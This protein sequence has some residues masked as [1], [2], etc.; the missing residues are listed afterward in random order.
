MRSSSAALGSSLFFAA[1]P[2]TVAGVVPWVLTRWRGPDPPW[3]VVVRAAGGRGLATP[4]GARGPGAGPPP[5]GSTTNSSPSRL[6]VPTSSPYSR[7]SKVRG[8][9]SSLTPW[10]AALARNGAPVS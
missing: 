7:K 5:S 1:A 6:T 9:R 10:K 4:A 3:P 8:A 2:G